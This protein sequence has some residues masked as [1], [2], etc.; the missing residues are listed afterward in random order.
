MRHPLSPSPSLS[1]SL[2]LVFCPCLS[3]SLYL[4]PFLSYSSALVVDLLSSFLGSTKKS[5]LRRRATET[6]DFVVDDGRV[7]LTLLI[8]MQHRLPVNW[9]TR[10]D[11]EIR[12]LWQEQE[13]TLVLASL[14][15][16]GVWKSEDL[17][18][19]LEVYRVR[20]DNMYKRVRGD[21]LWKNKRK[22]CSDTFLF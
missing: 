4:S 3:F 20:S 1:L 19:W 10:A 17:E 13:G 11:W 18:I 5:D 21:S 8:C 6:W 2:S 16:V 12:S 15:K 9:E 7:T 22:M 14:T